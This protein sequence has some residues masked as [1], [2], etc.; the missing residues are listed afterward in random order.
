MVITK[1]YMESKVTPNKIDLLVALP[2]VIKWH[3]HSQYQ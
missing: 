1:Y 2:T 3:S